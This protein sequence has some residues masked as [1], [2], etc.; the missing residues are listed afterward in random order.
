[1]CVWWSDVVCTYELRVFFPLVEEAF[2]FIIIIV[3]SFNNNYRDA[4]F[5]LQFPFH[6][7]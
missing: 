5:Q 3:R 1:M 7:S 6:K 4:A 2:I